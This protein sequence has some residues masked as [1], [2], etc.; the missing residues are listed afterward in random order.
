MAYQ[1]T[2]FAIGSTGV[3]N[4]PVSFVPTGYKLILN[5]KIGTTQNFAAMSF[6]WF[7]GTNQWYESFF[8]SDTLGRKFQGST[9]VAYLTESQAGSAICEA[10][11]SSITGGGTPT[12]DINILATNANY[13][14]NLEY[15]N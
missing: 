2:N 3:L 10:S 9:K 6:G 15:W 5:K 11:H 8:Q 4:I 13:N 1:V 7:D 12:I 14:W